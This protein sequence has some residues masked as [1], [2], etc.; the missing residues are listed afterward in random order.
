M[1]IVVS[2]RTCE[3]TLGVLCHEK[4]RKGHERCMEKYGKKGK[5]I[6]LFVGVLKKKR[7]KVGCPQAFLNRGP[8]YP[9]RVKKTNLY[10]PGQ[11]VQVNGEY[12]LTR[13]YKGK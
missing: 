5:K 3:D 4:E 13:E 12:S 11:G 8:E 1:Q 10:T 7:K 9:R 6:K 2:K